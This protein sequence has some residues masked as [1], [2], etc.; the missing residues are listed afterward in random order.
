MLGYWRPHSVFVWDTI[1]RLHDLAALFPDAL[2]EYQSQISKVLILNL[3]PLLDVIADLYSPIGRPAINQAE[4]FRSFILMQSLHLSIDAWVSKLAHNPV[5]RAAVGF[6]DDSFPDVGSYYDFISRI[7]K[8]DDSPI[9]RKPY[10]KPLIQLKKGEKLPPKKTNAV[11]IIVE[12]IIGINKEQSFNRRMTRRQERHLQEIFA[13]VAVDSSLKMGL[14]PSS[15]NIS[16]DGTCIATG[17]SNHGKNV[18]GCRDKGV[19]HCDC[20]RSFSDRHA[21]WGR[22]SHNEKFYYGYTGYFLSTYNP[23]LKIDLPLHIKLVQA[24]RHDSHSA[25]FSLAE[26]RSLHPNL[27]I[28]AFISDSASDNYATFELLNYWRINAVIALNG[29]N[30]GNVKYTDNITVNDKGVPICSGGYAMIFNGFCK[31]RCRLKWRC[32]RV[33][34]K[35]A[36]CEA[37]ENC[38]PSPY[39]RV[40]YT[41]PDWDLRLFTKIPRGSEHWKTIMKQRT[42]AERVNDR[43]MQDYG[44]EYTKLRGKKRI[45]FF[46]T[47]AAFNIHLDAQL[48]HLTAQGEFDFSKKLGLKAS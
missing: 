12:S 41:K 13:R 10:A 20:P 15:L 25:V 36:P 34:G 39:G 1:N 26:F 46:S 48:K 9:I 47:I 16:G 37:C 31:D 42:A 27:H 2:F 19:Y 6:S 11:S 23:A 40:K 18:C 5:L 14:L 29:T 21:N 30:K 28:D 24:N 7:Y 33:C 43:I 32:P 44:M 4:I 35:A 3:D 17:A 45:A 8:V 38:S 22:D